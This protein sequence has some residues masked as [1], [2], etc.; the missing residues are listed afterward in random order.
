[1]ISI[2]IPTYNGA[3]LL[4]DCL[5]S[6]FRQSFMEFEVTVVD[7]NS[8]DLSHEVFAEFKGR[9]TVIGLEE[10]KGFGSAVNRGIARS[11]GDLILVLNNDTALHSD[12]LREIA[13]A[14][15]RHRDYSFFAPKICEYGNVERI[16]AAGLMFSTRGYGNRSQR[17]ELQGVSAPREVFGA[18]GAAAVYRREVLDEVGLFNEA[19]F[20]LYEDLELSFRHQLRGHKC[21]YLP[22]AVIS[23]HGSAT[24]RHYFSAAAKEGIKNSLITL[25]SCAPA[26]FLRRHWREVSRFYLRFWL[27]FIRRGFAPEL[28]E[29]LLGVG[30][31]LHWVLRR[32]KT[33]QADSR[34]DLS[35]F[36]SL[37]Y[38]GVIRVNF[39]S[40]PVEL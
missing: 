29:A 26:P 36:N 1:M 17:E 30:G 22:S 9:I 39:P 31:K 16:Y 13:A 37:L 7:N 25:I 14:A 11:T 24:L 28:C 18:C 6:I 21:L 4:R 40:G 2:V 19:F 27:A 12:C 38:D 35:H 34:I 3:V 8:T 15:E 32:R 20:F 10:N 23:H 33:L 5:D